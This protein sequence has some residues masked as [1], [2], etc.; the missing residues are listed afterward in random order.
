[1]NMNSLN[2]SVMSSFQYVQKIFKRLNDLKSLLEVH[3]S[4]KFVKRVLRALSKSME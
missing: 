1:M 3:D 4:N 2:V